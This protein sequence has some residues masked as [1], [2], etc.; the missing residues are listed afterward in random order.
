MKEKTT[1]K[2]DRL[3][4]LVREIINTEAQMTRIRYRE[5]D[6]SLTHSRKVDYR[7]KMDQCAESI[8]RLR[9]EIHVEVVNLDLAEAFDSSYYEPYIIGDTKLQHPKPKKITESETNE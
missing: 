8:E 6:D 4:H 1:S 9:D 5:L 3:L 7:I 2:Y